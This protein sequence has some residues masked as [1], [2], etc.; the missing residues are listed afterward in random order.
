MNKRFIS[1]HVS[2][3]YLPYEENA[4]SW[5]G[6]MRQNNKETLRE[7]LTLFEKKKIGPSIHLKHK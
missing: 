7:D 5:R 3:K 6:K 2:L 1:K 4:C